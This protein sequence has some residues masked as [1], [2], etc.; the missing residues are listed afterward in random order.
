MNETVE[1]EKCKQDKTLDEV[2]KRP[3]CSIEYDGV[4]GKEDFS[5]SLPHYSTLLYIASHH[6]TS[7][8]ITSHH[9]TS[10]YSMHETK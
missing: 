7:H 2:D 4:D 8:H 9:I 6:I 3:T 5:Q 1:C 10:Q